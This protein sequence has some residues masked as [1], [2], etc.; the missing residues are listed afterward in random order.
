VIEH[1]AIVVILWVLA[2]S[3]LAAFVGFMIVST[4]IV[5]R[6]LWQLLQKAFADEKKA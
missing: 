4:I 6:H 2:I 5:F 1:L 3:G